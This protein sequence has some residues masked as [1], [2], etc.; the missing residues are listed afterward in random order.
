MYLAKGS[1]LDKGQIKVKLGSPF[2][3]NT[4]DVPGSFYILNTN[5]GKMHAR[6]VG[7]INYSHGYGCCPLGHLEIIWI[8]SPRSIEYEFE[9]IL[10][11]WHGW[12]DY[13]PC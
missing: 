10:F 8:I 4:K 12:A 11:P 2:F 1:D 5:S 6:L 3:M 9:S 7:E 13:A